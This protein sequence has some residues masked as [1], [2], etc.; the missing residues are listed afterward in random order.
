M[1]FLRSLVLGAALIAATA[2]HVPTATAPETQAVTARRVVLVSFDGM[3]ALRH[4]ELVARGAYADPDGLA[5]FERAY[6]VERAIPVDPTLTSVSHASI[7]TGA[8]PSRTGIVSNV[9][10]LPGTPITAWVSGFDRTSEAET[11]WQAFRRQGRR[12]GVLCFPGHDGT[13]PARSADFGMAY[14]N[15]SFARPASVRLAASE[16]EAAAAPAAPRRAR[17]AVELKGDGLEQTVT[18]HLAAVDAHAGGVDRLDAL[19]VDDDPDPANG[20]LATVG[21]GEWFPLVVRAPHRD[22]GTRLVGAWCLLQALPADLDGV[23]IHRGAFRATEAYPRAFREALDAG[24]GFWPGPPDDP[25]L[26]RGLDGRDGLA[27]TD[28]MAQARR[29]SEFFT[30]CAR[31]AL[32]TETFDLLLAYQPIPDEV[33][34][35]LLFTDQRQGR[36]SPELAAAGGRAIDDTFRLVDRAVGA[37]ARGLDLGRDALVVVSDHGMA[38]AVEAVHLN[39][40]LRRAGL[41]DAEEADGRP[42]VAASSRIVAV[43]SSGCAHLVVNLA[44]RE[45]GGTVP[46]AERDEVVRAAA[47]ALALLEV[48]GEPVVESMTRHEEAGALGLD[49]P[50]AGDLVVFMKPGFVATS[51]IGGALHEPNPY[52]GQHGYRNVHP[53]VA[54]VWLARGAGVPRARRVEAPLTGVAAFVAALAGVEPPAQAQR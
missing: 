41:A 17:L 19:T 52:A 2:C 20:V 10:H 42:R 5:A 26:E 14:V 50:N 49:H 4:R 36:Y 29:F 37:L 53:E 25:A 22:G 45:P 1:Q 15:A 46:A 23:R 54:G 31:V 18:F 28:Y 34:H 38:T 21:E 27:L 32:A 47:R 9:F 3:A 39:E 35:A 7:A 6:V 40:A 43:S 24:A 33:E 51:R 13:T 44:G 16:F 30:A 12:V 48:D 8:P 11:L